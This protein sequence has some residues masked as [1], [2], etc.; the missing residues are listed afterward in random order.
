MD[1]QRQES[2]G[3]SVSQSS[4]CKPSF[5]TNIEVLFH[6][7]YIVSLLSPQS[8][9]GNHNAQLSKISFNCDCQTGSA[10]SQP[11]VRHNN[12]NQSLNTQHLK[13]VEVRL[14]STESSHF[15]IFLLSHTDNDNWVSI[16]DTDLA[17]FVLKT[18]PFFKWEISLNINRI[19]LHY[20]VL[21]FILISL[22]YVGEYGSQ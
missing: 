8:V 11:P 7:K 17:N 5:P 14:E 12:Y 21:F 1:H 3:K 9:L 15:I 4:V 10:V 19:L 13:Y 16:I 2:W 22:F 20:F 6:F 18:F